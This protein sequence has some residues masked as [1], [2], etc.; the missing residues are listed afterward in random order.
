MAT[1]STIPGS[2][3]GTSNVPSDTAGTLGRGTAGGLA[4]LD[5]TGNIPAGQLGNVSGGG[6]GAFFPRAQ[7]HPFANGT[8]TTFF[9]L[10]QTGGTHPYSAYG[11]AFTDETYAGVTASNM[12][13]GYNPGNLDPTDSAAMFWKMF[14]WA[15]D[16]HSV[17][18]LFNWTPPTGVGGTFVNWLFVLGSRVNGGLTML[19][20][21]GGVSTDY[22]Q[23]AS[24]YLQDQGSTNGGKY[25]VMTATSGFNYYVGGVIRETR[26]GQTATTFSIVGPSG[27]ATGTTT[28]LV[29]QANTGGMCQMFLQAGATTLWRIQSTTSSLSFLDGQNSTRLTFE[30]L[31]G[32]TSL[33]ASTL[34]NSKV[35]V[36]SSLVVGN[37]AL[38]T[39]A[40]DGFLY[41]PTCP[42]APTG[43]PSAKTGTT[44]TIY[45]TTDDKLYVYNGAWR[46]VTLA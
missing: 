5:G 31:P 4:T 12:C 18:W 36:D 43:V 23:F 24:K 19:M 44:A 40:T 6:T 26:A 38:A 10:S 16:T 34:I 28:N 32:A 15:G 8:G 11:M 21:S 35:I 9:Q 1:G 27:D 25:L 45:D 42:G 30:I 3:T 22:I 39:A 33:A 7:T 2:M 46:S 29:L 14:T 37:A 41:L 20:Q 17:E 13:F